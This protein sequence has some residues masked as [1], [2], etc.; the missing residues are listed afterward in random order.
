MVAIRAFFHETTNTASY[1]VS[2]PDSGRCAIVDSVLDYDQD[3]ARTS[4]GAAD[5]IAAHVTDNGLTVDWILETHAHA[6]HLTA[7]PYL[8]ERL[9]G[10]VGIGEHVGE[11]Q[12]IFRDIFN[13]GPDFAVDGSQFDH[14]FS[15]GE[16]FAIGGIEVRVMHT[17]G[18]TPAC[19][20]YV[21]DDAAF[22][23]DTMF[24]PDY[25][26][27]R[28]DFPGGDAATLYR[29]IRNILSLPPETRLF[30]CHDYKAPGRDDYEWETTVA[31]QT[32]ENVH[33]QGEEADFVQFRTDRDRQLNMPVL[34]LPSV[35][36]NIRAGQ[37]PPP[38]DNGIVYFRIPV[39]TL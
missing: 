11:V 32:A 26:T 30:L 18:H 17:P 16:T 1:V 2:D 3:A 36:V 13:L 34:I 5:E 39:N 19:V 27:A 8:K 25:G 9:G 24:M 31:R 4:T 7:A 15:D 33:L 12:A 22:I 23:G 6:D 14:L 20:T 10:K 29:S 37:F 35:Q 38:D 28:V 21:V